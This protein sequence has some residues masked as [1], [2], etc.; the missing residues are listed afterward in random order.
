M[1]DNKSKIGQQDRDRVNVNESYELQYWSEKFNVAPE[2]LR[3]AVDKVG[4]MVKDIEQELQNKK[5]RS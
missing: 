4:V 2:E 3:S 5:K 1:S